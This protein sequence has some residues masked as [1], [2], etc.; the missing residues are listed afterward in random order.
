MTLV[1]S[2]E[3]KNEYFMSGK[4][5][6]KFIFHEGQ[7][8]KW[9]IHFFTSWDEIKVISTPKIWMFFYKFYWRWEANLIFCC[10]MFDL[11]FFSWQWNIKTWQWNIKIL[12]LTCESI[13]F[14]KYALYSSNIFLYFINLYTI[15]VPFS[16]QLIQQ[17]QK[18]AFLYEDPETN[19]L[20]TKLATPINL[21]L[22]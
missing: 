10:V 3:V 22:Q 5:S 8:H 13:T 1:S 20:P 15:N 12:Y 11:Q 7:S 6:E 9:N 16:L 19:W 4:W 2:N 17:Q 21:Q 14:R 18:N